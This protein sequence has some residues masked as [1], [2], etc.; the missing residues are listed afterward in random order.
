MKLNLI[1]KWTIGLIIAVEVIS[2]IKPFAG[3][4][5]P[6]VIA[7]C[8]PTRERVNG[9]AVFKCDNRP[10]KCRSGAIVRINGKAYRKLSCRP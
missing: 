2:L 6:P 1:A 10:S 4:I 3:K 9:R 8:F 5:T 7:A